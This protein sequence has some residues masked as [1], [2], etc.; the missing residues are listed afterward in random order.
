MELLT[1]LTTKKPQPSHDDF[2]ALQCMIFIKWYSMKLFTTLPVHRG[3]VLSH[4]VSEDT[5]HPNL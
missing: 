3:I 1:P 4:T 2:I 5:E